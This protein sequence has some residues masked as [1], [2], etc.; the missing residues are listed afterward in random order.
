MEVILNPE[1]VS[2]F[3]TNAPILVLRFLGLVVHGDTKDRYKH[4][5]NIRGCNWIVKE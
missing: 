1:L 4:S 3:H 2:M 5:N